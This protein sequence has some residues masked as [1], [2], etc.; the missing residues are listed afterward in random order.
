MCR[1][2]SRRRTRRKSCCRSSR[3]RGQTWYTAERRWET[4][5][6]AAERQKKKGKGVGQRQGGGKGEQ[7]IKGVERV[8][9]GEE[10]EAI[11]VEGAMYF[12]IGEV[13]GE[14]E[15]EEDKEGYEER[16]LSPLLG[17]TGRLEDSSGEAFGVKKG[18][19][20]ADLR[21]VAELG[22]QKENVAADPVVA[23][24]QWGG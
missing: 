20:F 9:G 1:K 4:W 22:A 12:F 5:K 13:E 24:L 17:E 19:V 21:V 7:Q 15:K 14:K 18:K 11:I 8:E 10:K 23:E 16:S 6:E 2:I 3:T